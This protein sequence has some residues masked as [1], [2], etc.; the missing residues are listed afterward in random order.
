MKRLPLTPELKQRLQKAAGDGVDVSNHAVYEATGLNTQAVRKDHPLYKGAKHTRSYLTQM[1][2]AV[3]GESLPLQVMHNDEQLPAGRVFYGEVIDQ[4]GGPELRTLFWVDPAKPELSSLIDSG[5]LDQVSVSTLAAHASCSMCGWDFLG[6]DS[7]I[8]TNIFGG[9]CKNSH[10]LGDAGAHVVMNDLGQW[11]EMSLVGRGGASGARI[12]TPADSML[13]LSAKGRN[14][15]FTLTLS[16][17]D[18]E[19]G[20]TLE[21]LAAQIAALGAKLDASKPKDDKEP[22][23]NT[24]AVGSLDD[25]SQRLAALEDVIK[26]MTEVTKA[27]ADVTKTP[28]GHT[29][30]AGN[31]LLDGTPANQL[32]KRILVMSGDVEAKVEGLTITDLLSKLDGLKTAGGKSLDAAAGSTVTE[33]ASGPKSNDAYKRR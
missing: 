13:A 2:Q 5:T 32:A 18:L 6:A 20:M 11:Y 30:D 28:E 31:F 1:A 15:L 22:N 7:D 3:N 21:Q 23:T 14:P 25:L 33:A 27:P 29:D 10:K 4:P 9:V 16:S 12:C 26:K 19:T 17:K 24:P 8:E